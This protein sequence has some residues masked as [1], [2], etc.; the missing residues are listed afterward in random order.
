MR[1]GSGP[2]RLHRVTGRAVT[3]GYLT[4][5]AAGQWLDHLATQPF[6]AST[7]LFIVTATAA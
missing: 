3:A 7:T 2:A 1:P 5:G 4:K 6:F